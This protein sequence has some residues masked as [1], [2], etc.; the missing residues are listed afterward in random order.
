[1]YLLNTRNIY[2]SWSWSWSH[3]EVL[4]LEADD[5]CGDLTNFLIGDATVGERTDGEFR[6][7]VFIGDDIN[8]LRERST[9]GECNGV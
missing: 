8:S 4:A 2:K 7:A 3:L 1:M 9:S 5:G 6:E